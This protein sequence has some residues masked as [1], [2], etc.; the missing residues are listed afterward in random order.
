V[1][2][3]GI[4]SVLFGLAGCVSYTPEPIGNDAMSRTAVTLSAEESEIALARLAETRLLDGSDVT[5]D[6][7]DGVSFTEAFVTALV[8]SPR[9]AEL[10]NETREDARRI[11]A[12]AGIGD[13]SLRASDDGMPGN[14]RYMSGVFVDVWSLLGAGPI[15]ARISRAEAEAA[16]SVARLHEA[17]WQL[18]LELREAFRALDLASRELFTYRAMANDVQTRLVDA[19]TVLE[20]L[21]RITRGD[22]DNAATLGDRITVR[23]RELE[24]AVYHAELALKEAIGLLPEAE[25][26]FVTAGRPW[27]PDSEWTPDT[28]RDRAPGARWDLQILLAQYQVAEEELRGEVRS[29]YPTIQIGPSYRWGPGGDIFGGA[30][31][32][33]FPDLATLS[34][35]VEAAEFRRAAARNRIEQQLL[36]IHHEI[37]NQWVRLEKADASAGEWRDRTLPRTRAAIDRALLE[38]RLDPD[39]FGRA[40]SAF[41]AQLSA[42]N[43]YW[44]LEAERFAAMTGLEQAAGFPLDM[45]PSR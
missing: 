42:V 41:S 28:L 10:R 31:N 32:L 24:L 29:Q 16:A 17:Q 23:I 4:V 39:R 8:L 35:R 34:A 30:L 27:A 1:W 38:A 33:T 5:L 18:Y 7:S 44:R 43:Q 14:R 11:L 25:L 36:S 3:V 45:F 12:V 9:L 2:I 19:S 37:E 22:L 20:Q 26:T 15:D 21:G 6:A 13:V 40:V